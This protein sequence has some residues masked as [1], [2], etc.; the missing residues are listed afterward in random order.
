MAEQ[1]LHVKANPFPYQGTATFERSGSAG[2]ESA[3]AP[4]MTLMLDPL[5]RALE[6]ARRYVQRHDPARREVG[7]AVVLRGDHGSGKTHSIRYLMSQVPDMARY[8]EKRE[9]LQLYV[10]AEGPSLLDVYRRLGSQLSF[11]DLR[12]LALAFVGV[13]A[14]LPAGGEVAAEALRATPEKIYRLFESYLVDQAEAQNRLGQEIR[15][16][17]GTGDFHYAL[18]YLLSDDVTL[19][20]SAY[21]WLLGDTTKPDENRKLGVASA[22]D[23]DKKAMLA[24]HVLTLVLARAGRPFYVYIDQYERL[25]LERN[26]SEAAANIGLLHTLVE[27]I[28]RENGMLLLSG[29]TEA[30]K[31]LPS[32]LHQRVGTGLVHHPRLTYEDA[33]DVLGL[34]LTP[35][36]R[37]F[38]PPI[39]EGELAPFSSEALREMLQLGGG[40]LRRLLQLANETFEAAISGGVSA[41]R[42]EPELVRRVAAKGGR[43]I[44]TERTVTTEL[45]RVARSLGYEV[46]AD[47]EVGSARADLAVL[48]AGRPALLFQ[49]RGAIFREDEARRALSTLN[50]VKSARD[51]GV[52]A[53][54]VLVIMGYASPLVTETVSEYVPEYVVYEPDS[55]EARIR[56]IME[57]PRAA[58]SSQPSGESEALQARLEE[59]QTK[60]ERAL[61]AGQNDTQVLDRRLTGVLE[62]Q[63]L[64]QAWAERRDK[65]EENIRELRDARRVAALAELERLRERAELEERR[66]YL[67]WAAVGV[68]AAAVL[69][70]ISHSEA[71]V[72]PPPLQYGQ[73]SYLRLMFYW[74]L[75]S[76]TILCAPLAWVLQAFNLIGPSRVRAL[77][78]RAYTFEEL[79]STATAVSPLP[80]WRRHPNPHFRYA[81]AVQ[82]AAD[83][84]IDELMARLTTESSA[85]VRVAIAR[86]LIV[87]ATAPPVGV[88]GPS[89]TQEIEARLSSLVAVR[90]SALI[91][92]SLASRDVYVRGMT[93]S[94]ELVA[95]L[96]LGGAN[97]RV[98][99]ALG[100]DDSV[101]TAY[102]VGLDK[103]EQLPD[104][105][106]ARLRQALKLLSPADGVGSIDELQSSVTIEELYLFFEE[107]TFLIDRA[108]D[109]AP[110]SKAGAA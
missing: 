39:S 88:A 83:C 77:R 82:D 57:R 93:R 69:Y 71:V 5:A 34:Y 106:R 61:Q 13:S 2:H 70:L 110:Q 53:E 14:T 108:T 89:K 86:A 33:R 66:K 8:A 85:L 97:S 43:P 21:R 107:L 42:I 51:A 75:L 16:L 28:P 105:S 24:L 49:V 52:R 92:E 41:E 104:I 29:T 38:S 64:R 74:S 98:F 80:S 81:W 17:G 90:E 91:V 3:R 6:L 26:A 56:E 48:D 62:K 103:V 1:Q 94:L 68:G 11:E 9:P 55:F 37:K 18:S 95:A 58:R 12:V 40:N 27:V 45:N 65:L 101:L 23:D 60:L 73:S 79:N 67:V 78:A 44:F 96:G 7:Q 15:R 100:V 20:Q 32:D 54:V 76:A 31:A 25:V 63:A 99:D 35:L 102:H 87:K 10:K 19:A 4:Y 59:L 30:W 22:I 109:P 47:L 84:P 46:V 36:D 50:L 72:P